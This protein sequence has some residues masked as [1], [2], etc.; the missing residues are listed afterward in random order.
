MRTF[1][2]WAGDMPPIVEACIETVRRNC[3]PDHIVLGPSDAADIAKR[4]D[5]DISQWRPSEISDMVRT[6]QLRVGGTW[7]DA[8]VIS[9]EGC[10]TFCEEA[11]RKDLLG[12]RA[13]MPGRWDDAVFG[14]CWDCPA[15]KEL[16][17]RLLGRCRRWSGRVPPHSSVNLWSE[18][19]RAFEMAKGLRVMALDRCHVFPVGGRNG[20]WRK[21]VEPGEDSATMFAHLTGRCVKYLH[22]SS[23]E[24][25]VASDTVVGKMLARA[26]G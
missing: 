9:F 26:L 14:C 20:Q 24:G 15:W 6:D 18:S 4:L 3:N 7:I 10:R 19:Q 25:I 11:E 13:E 8:D 16:A 2:Y 23:V 21:Y 22:R 17:D 12:F 5:L 1:T